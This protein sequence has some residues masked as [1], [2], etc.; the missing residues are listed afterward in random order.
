MQSKVGSSIYG[1]E[2]EFVVKNVPIRDTLGPEGF[3]GEFNHMF[4]EGTAAPHLHELLPQPN[5]RQHFP[6]VC[7]AGTTWMPEPERGT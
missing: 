5:K 2:T 4:G 6:A 7:R 1:K 3:P